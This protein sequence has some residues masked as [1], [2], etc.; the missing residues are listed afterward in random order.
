VKRRQE[1]GARG[2][3]IWIVH[4]DCIEDLS[5]LVEAA[6]GFHHVHFS[7]LKKEGWFHM[8]TGTADTAWEDAEFCLYAEWREVPRSQRGN[9]SAGHLISLYDVLDVSRRVR[10]LVIDSPSS[11][12][13]KAYWWGLLKGLP[14]IEELGLSSSA[15]ALDDAWKNTGPSVLPALRRVRIGSLQYTI[16]GD[17][18]PRRIVRLASD[19][20]TLPGEES[21]ENE[22]E[23]MSSGLL[24]LLQGLELG[25][26]IRRKLGNRRY[27]TY[28]TR[29]QQK[30][31]KKPLTS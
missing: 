21:A 10:R 26:R 8:R 28:T 18:P 13:L 16:I 7:G 1:L 14:G 29:L 5:T 24:R 11:G 31:T 12:T 4:E 19:D 15:D 6:N 22:V 17:T 9:V 27:S 23:I 2:P 3:Y 30:K 25:N 20:V